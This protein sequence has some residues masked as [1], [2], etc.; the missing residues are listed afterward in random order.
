[1]LKN[2]FSVSALTLVSR[3]LGFVRDIILANVL[4][5]GAIADAFFVAFRIPNHFRAILAEGAFNAAFVPAFAK[6]AAEKGQDAALVFADRIFAFLLGAQVIIVLSALVFMPAVVSVLAPGLVADMGR[7]GLAVELTRITF[8][9]LAFISLVVLVS[10]VLN[11]VGRFAAAAA[12]AILMNLTVIAALL[13]AGYFPT[14]AHAGAWGVLA[15]G[16]FQFILVAVAAL[17]ANIMVELRLPKITEDVKRF[18]KNFVPA[19]AGSAGTQIAVFADTII[20]SFLVAGAISW[21]YYADRINQLPI[22]VIA[23]AVGTVLLSEMSRRIASGDDAGARRAQLRAIELTLLFSLPCVAAFVLVPDTIM[24]ALFMHGAF[25]ANDAAMSARALSAYGLGLAAFVLLRAFTITFHARGDTRT[26]VIAMAVAISIN[27]AL[28]LVLMGPM[29][30]VGLAL[31]TGVGA[32]I[33]LSLL[34]WF[35]RRQDL[36]GLDDRARQVLPRL[37]V[38]FLVLAA[39]LLVASIGLKSALGPAASDRLKLV[40]LMV[41]GGVSYGGALI[42]LFGRQ[43]VADIKRAR[44]GG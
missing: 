15:A 34:Y 40:I 39:A 21:L 2:I 23:V 20:A 14:A 5:A 24:R 35:A 6:T 32:W 26:P 13:M 7:F 17:R 27:I 28:K 9:Y 10:G 4:G 18:W 3:A 29:G 11:A 22:G 44:R 19:M 37:G 42:A 12:T 43:I 41:V 38:A 16:L 25:S 36:M 33:N 1:M 30:H 8:P 31:A